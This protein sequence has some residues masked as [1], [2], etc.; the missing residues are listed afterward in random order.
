MQPLTYDLPISKGN[1]RRVVSGWVILGILS[2]VAAGI[3]SLLLVLARTP[4]IQSLVPF[5][6]FFR[7][8]LVVHFNLSVLVWL[9]SITAASWSLSSRFERRLWDRT[10]FWLAA[11]GALVMVLAPFVGIRRLTAPK[12]LV[13][14]LAFSRRF[15]I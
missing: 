5:V 8:A 2:L 13:P 7:I 4:I 14:L 10:S 3:F 15:L 9:L 11:A 12:L 6:D 1:N